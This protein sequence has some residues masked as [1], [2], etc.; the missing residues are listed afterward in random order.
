MKLFRSVWFTLLL[1]LD[2][3]IIVQGQILSSLIC[4]SPECNRNLQD[5][6]TILTD[7]DSTSPDDW[8]TSLTVGCKIGCISCDEGFYLDLNSDCQQIP[9]CDSG[10]YLDSR[11][12]CQIIPTCNSD[13]YL[14]QNHL[15]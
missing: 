4:N 15:C 2:L 13:Q 6:Q 12:Q 5:Q 14:D 8:L 10:Y 9:T 1:A 3:A 11:F 7:S